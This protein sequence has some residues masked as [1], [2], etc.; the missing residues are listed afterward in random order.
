MW[1][2][3]R[4][5]EGWRGLG[6]GNDC[7]QYPDRGWA[8]RSQDPYRPS[9]SVAV[10]NAPLVGEPTHRESQSV[11]SES[12]SQRTTLAFARAARGNR[13]ATRGAC[14]HF[15]TPRVFRIV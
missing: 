11:R 14:A 4:A 1:D 3:E 15:S 5:W 2:S 9:T 7:W 12:K 10:A 8:V 13:P 6:L